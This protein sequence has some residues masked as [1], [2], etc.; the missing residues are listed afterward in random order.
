MLNTYIYHQLPST[1]FC[2]CYTIFRE[3]IALPAQ[4]T[5]RFF[6]CCWGDVLKKEGP[7]DYGHEVTSLLERHIS[8]SFPSLSCLNFTCQFLSKL[9]V[10]RS[11]P[12]NSSAIVALFELA[13]NCNALSRYGYPCYWNGNWFESTGTRG[14]RKYLQEW[15]QC[16]WIIHEFSCFKNVPIFL[17]KV[18]VNRI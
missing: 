2:V 16:V 5:V 13:L 18:A 10:F 17:N 9:H 1:C 7:F 11:V 8:Y 15:Q 6:V 14:L 12:L 3:T 4:K